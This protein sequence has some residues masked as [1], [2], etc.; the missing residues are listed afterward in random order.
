MQEILTFFSTGDGTFVLS[1]L[2]ISLLLLRAP[3]LYLIKS[4]RYRIKVLV[5]QGVTYH[6]PST[7]HPFFGWWE[8][9][10]HGNLAYSMND[11]EFE[12]KTIAMGAIVKRKEVI[13][14]RLKLKNKSKG[15]KTIKHEY[16]K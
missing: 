10:K 7:Y 14:A 9:T 8:L 15:D 4:K 11:T 12:D 3:V 13:E 5:K 6:E 16:F 2:I 1:V